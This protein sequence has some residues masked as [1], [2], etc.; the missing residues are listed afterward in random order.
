MCGL[1]QD[2]LWAWLLTV[3]VLASAA[4]AQTSD[5]A[6]FF[7]SKIRP[8]F[9]AKC[10]QCHGRDQ[11]KGGL[12]LSRPEG[13]QRDGS[14]SSRPPIVVPGNAAASALIL[15]IQYQDEIKMPPTGKLSGREIAGLIRWVEMGA[16]WPEQALTT[17]VKTRA[18][19]QPISDEERA[20]WAFQPVEDQK[21]P[22]VENEAWVATPIDRFLLMRM[23]VEGL[24]PAPPTDRLTLLRRVTYDLT[25]LPPTEH[26]I[27]DFL[28]DDD[29]DAYR[30]VVERLLDSSRYGERWGRHWLDVARYADS[31]GVDEDHKYPYAWKYRDYVI[32][33]FNDDLPFDR[34]V[35]EQIAG[36]LLPPRGESPKPGEVNARGIIATGF[37]ALGPKLIAEQDKKKMFYDIVDEQIEVVGKAILG[38]TLQ[39]ARCHDHKF[40][41]IRTRDYYSMASIFASTRQ[42]ED[43]EAH[44]SKLYFAPLVPSAI[45]DRYYSQQKEISLKKQEIANVV[46][47]QT[48]RHVMRLLPQ[49]PPYLVAAREVATATPAER[50]AAT[51]VSTAE[52]GAPPSHQ[53]VPKIAG[54]RSLDA[55]LLGRW[56]EYLKP[57]KEVRPHLDRWRQAAPASVEAVAREYQVGFEKT[58]TKRYQDLADWR[59]KFAEAVAKGKEPPEK[60]RFFAGENRFFTETTSAKGPL[61]VTKEE[62]ERVFSTDALANLTRLEA[63]FDELK[64]SLPPKPPMANAVAEDKPVEQHVFISGN[65]RQLGDAAP[66]SFPVIL[67]GEDQPA[68][69]EG[70][71]RR[72]LARWL[73]SPENPLTARVIVNRIW[74]WHFGEG[75]VRTPNNFGK[76]GERPTH[77]ELLDYLAAEF[78]RSGWSIKAMHRLILFS[79]AYRMSTEV[80][81]GRYASDPE[82]RGWSRFSR[83]RMDAEEIRDSLLAIE[84]TIDF[85][86]G[87][88][89]QTGI[90]QGMTTIKQLPPFDVSK[91]YRR[92]VYLPLRRANIAKLLTLFDFGDA[93]T[94]TGARAT[95]NVAP[96]ALFMMNS[97]L[98]ARAAKGLA[99]RVLAE[100]RMPDEQRVRSAWL[101]VLAKQPTEAEVQEALAYVREFQEG[102]ADRDLMEIEG[103]R[104]EEGHLSP[105]QPA[106]YY[107]EARLAAWQSYGKILLAS[108]DFIYIQ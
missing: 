74:Q 105:D 58:A 59:A 9:A 6:E 10:V 43:W 45:A 104:Q 87:G 14:S 21:P 55:D 98:V 67:A 80:D 57:T 38:L 13:L 35:Q 75:L 106:Y 30:N 26:E 66:K 44:V 95:T 94:S 92:T 41:P 103:S 29:A 84:G 34:F 52:T 65:V 78:V 50:E 96:Q 107:G 81:A 22:A 3:S 46:D 27:R 63:Q 93:T 25:G 48:A 4:R 31:T 19:G 69:T 42:L 18:P 36:D 60:P 90:G 99:R 64:K 32:D 72:E 40:D 1:A 47:E 73:S 5:T 20:F 51:D 62:R 2:R 79:N 82:N 88:T 102:A 100:R 7:E 12:D 97:E 24:E 89:L 33:A 37:L 108:N 17:K 49:L 70:S 85:G 16:P 39:C 77:P 91:S 76:L 28:K 83:R 15:A 56:V 11:Q 23:E 53:T 68:M 86:M 54:K 101:T 71:G 61:G 8:L